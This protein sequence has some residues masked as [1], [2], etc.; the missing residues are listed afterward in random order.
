MLTQNNIDQSGK[1]R[2]FNTEAA[3]WDEKSSRVQLAGELFE[4]LCARAPLDATLRVMDFGCGTGLLTL[5]LAPH[6]QSIVGV[7]ASPGMLEVF[8]NK[9]TVQ[10]LSN[11]QSVLID[12]ATDFKLHGRYDRIVSTMTLHHVE[13]IE[14]LLR[15]FFEHLDPGGLLCIADLDLDGGKFHDSH[16]EVYH[17][18]FCRSWL[19]RTMEDAGFT[20]VSDSTA[21][22]IV[23]PDVDGLTRRFGVFLMIGQRC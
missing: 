13:P 11:V 8:R 17:P 19:R 9:A 12:P 6:V 1:Q 15:K 14:A 3:T 23:K 5:Q 20:H 7:D 22:E 4:A 18:G 10:Q 16:S 2:D 21:T